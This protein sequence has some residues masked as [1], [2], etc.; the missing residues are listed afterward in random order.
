MGRT[1]RDTLTLRMKQLQQSLRDD[2]R[3]ERLKIGDY[4]PSEVEL[5]KRFHISKETVRRALDDLVAEG[6]IIKIRRV[7]NKVA[8]AV[9][10]PASPADERISVPPAPF[11][12][13]ADHFDDTSTL[14]NSD[15]ETITLK[16]AYNPS[17]EQETNLSALISLFELHNPG[18]RIQLIPSPFPVEL[19]QHGIADV[20]TV[21]SWDHLK[22]RDQDPSLRLLAPPPVTESAARILESHFYN[23]KG[24]I[25]AA[26]FVFSPIVLCYNRDHLETC[27]IEEPNDSWTW[28]TLLKHARK[29]SK[30][31]DIWGFA[32]HI[33]SLNR[34]P[35]FLLQN[36]FRF[37]I[38]EESKVSENPIMWESLRMAR[39][40]VQQQ[41]STVP[42]LTENDTDAERWFREG[43][44]SMIMTTYYGMNQFKHS[45]I[46]YGVA[47]LPSLRTSDT[48]MLVA[49]LAQSSATPYPEA[50]RRLIQ[51]LCGD[52]AQRS[53]RRETLSLPAHPM[54]LKLTADLQGNRPEVEVPMDQLWPYC[55][56]YQDLNLKAN[57]IDAIRV[58]LKGFWSY[59]E[60]QWETGERLELV[61]ARSE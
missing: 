41:R 5:A 20:F 10:S 50:S 35:V 37:H 52:I 40:L 57:V 11:S 39:D 12:V 58:E 38:S 15:Q 55:K 43:K 19:A 44:A 2:I 36:E 47:P 23:H 32:A 33:Q 48:L 49:G 51:F 25:T 16:L 30:E 1:S 17:L 42:L 28:Y 7:G 26:P 22:L 31:L 54:A 21:S 3:Q 56:S 29:L 14:N 6:I 45:N 27:G 18:I 9:N 34:W 13:E 4:I 59:I 46:R 53:V 60:D 24:Q 61:L 8:G